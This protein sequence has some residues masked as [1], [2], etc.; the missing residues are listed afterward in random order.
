NESKQAKAPYALVAPIANHVW[1]RGR[2]NGKTEQRSTDRFQGAVSIVATACEQLAHIAIPP[3][4]HADRKSL[5]QTLREAH[6]GLTAFLKKIEQLSEDFQADIRAKQARREETAHE[7]ALL[8]AADEAGKLYLDDE[9][10]FAPDDP[11]ADAI[12]RER[13]FLYRAEQSALGAKINL[14]NLVCT[15]AMIQAAKQAVDAW[16]TTYH[17]LTA[18]AD[19]VAAP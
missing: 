3:L 12:C 17:E 16:T 4:N 6:A 19:E 15:K 13:G 9:G 10:N 8:A 18:A 7:E 11:Q 1:G 5:L 14:R 2:R